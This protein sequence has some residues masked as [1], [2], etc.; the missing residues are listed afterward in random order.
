ME[1]SKFAVSFIAVHDGNETVDGREEV[2]HVKLT[3]FLLD[4]GLEERG[5][6]ATIA[7]SATVEGQAAKVS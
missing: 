1:V 4:D 7:I 5:L 2:T 3:V 6:T